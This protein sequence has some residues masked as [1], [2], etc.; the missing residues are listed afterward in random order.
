MKLRYHRGG[1]KTGVPQVTQEPGLPNLESYKDSCALA[2]AGS[3]LGHHR[4]LHS[5]GLLGD[6]R[7]APQPTCVC[8]LT[9]VARRTQDLLMGPGGCSGYVWVSDCDRHFPT[10]A[11]C[12][13]GARQERQSWSLGPALVS[14]ETRFPGR[15]HPWWNW[16]R[17]GF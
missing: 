2:A 9:S 17:G 4:R 16:N 14:G 6:G 8:W 3:P 5:A 15:Q 13:H 11:C 12:S 1:T 7:R 10:M